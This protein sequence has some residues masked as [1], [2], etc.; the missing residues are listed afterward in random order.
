MSSV[1]QWSQLLL[2]LKSICQTFWMKF[3]ASSGL[4]QTQ[5]LT[6]R[7]NE[8]TVDVET[9]TKQLNDDIG[10]VEK[11]W[12]K[13][14]AGYWR[15][16]LILVARFVQDGGPVDIALKLMKNVPHAYIKEA[17]PVQM[18][19]YPDFCQKMCYLAEQFRLSQKVE[20]PT[21]RAPKVCILP[22]ADA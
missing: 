17:L 6:Q 11:R 1:K 10:A 21:F 3:F 13:E 12:R 4:N 2:R 8:V 20:P 5:T 19:A 9:L 15:E 22:R 18:T 14:T 16:M 7:G